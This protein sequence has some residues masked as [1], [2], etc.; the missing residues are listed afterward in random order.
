MARRDNQKIKTLK[1]YDILRTESDEDHPI[2]TNEI[3]ERLDG[4]DI[5]CGRKALSSDVDLLNQYGYGVKVVRSRQNLYYLE[6]RDLDIHTIRFLIDATQSATFLSK[7]QTKE[8]VSGLAM[9]AGTNR[10]EVL[11]D[12]VI[13][14][15][16]LKHSNNEVLRNITLINRAIEKRRKISIEYYIINVKGNPEP[17]TDGGEVKRY[18]KS[19]IAMIYSGGYYYLIAY[20]EKYDD[21]VSFRMDRMMSVKM[22]GENPD[23]DKYEQ[24]FRNSDIKDSMTAFGMW[25]GKT[26][27]V[28]LR[29]LNQHAGDVFDKFGNQ[30]KLHA[31]KDGRFTVTVQVNP[32]DPVFLG[33]CMSYGNELEVISPEEVKTALRNRAEAI[34]GLYVDTSESP[35]HK[36]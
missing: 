25:T 33:W 4:E 1:I 10:A 17:K 9:L 29:L 26:Q 22:E 35:T 14:F 5:S 20:Q 13:C 27:S 11:N 2:S 15:D 16:K 8:I 19:P 7:K 30:V 3:I 34:C 32:D 12:N 18:F 23:Y 28:R 21:F 36:K 6:N 31:E 24:K